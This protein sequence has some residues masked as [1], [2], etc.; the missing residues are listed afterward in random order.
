METIYIL[1]LQHS[2]TL[3]QNEIPMY[4]VWK[5]SKTKTASIGSINPS[6]L[7]C[8]QLVPNC[9]NQ[10][11]VPSP[12]IEKRGDPPLGSQGALLH[13]PEASMHD[14][15]SSLILYTNDFH[16]CFASPACTEFSTAK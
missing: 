4:Q 9:W 8:L 13:L 7:F 3:Y 16:Q 5:R 15:I 6:S 2:I 1:I 11:A 14:I 10:T 12:S